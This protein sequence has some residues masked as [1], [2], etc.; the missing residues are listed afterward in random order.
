MTGTGTKSYGIIPPIH[1]QQD[2]EPKQGD[3]RVSFIFWW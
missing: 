2:V 3:E 1:S